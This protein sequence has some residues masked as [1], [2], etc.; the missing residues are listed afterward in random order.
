[1]LYYNEL[2][3]N[4]YSQIPKHGE[5]HVIKAE[6]NI[7]KLE[8]IIL[9][10]LR[11][12]CDVN[13]M[14]FNNTENYYWCKIENNFKCLLYSEIKLIANDSESSAIIITN[15]SDYQLKLRGIKKNFKITKIN[16]LESLKEGLN[17]YQ[18]STFTCCWLNN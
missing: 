4:I 5:V 13:V 2:P 14:G 7:K 9:T 1:M 10:I 16:F 18:N 8:D 17:L 3:Y 12:F 15:E 11:D 6:L